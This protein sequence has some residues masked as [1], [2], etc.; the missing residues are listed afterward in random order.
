MISVFFRKSGLIVIIL[1]LLLISN[2]T[3]F[4]K[5]DQ[6]TP[7]RLLTDLICGSDEFSAKAAVELIEYP[8]TELQIWISEFKN[9]P[10]A[11]RTDD[12]VRGSHHINDSL[13]APFYTYV[14]DDYSRDNPTPLVIWLHGGVS[15]D[16]FVGEDAEDEWSK[17]PMVELAAKE[18]DMEIE[19]DGDGVNEKGFWNEKVIVSIDPKYFRPTEV[20]TLLGD[21]SKAKEKL[22]WEPKITLEEMVHEMMENDINIAKRDSLVK[23]HGF[24][25]PDFNE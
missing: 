21:P 10:K 7:N 12:L 24:K 15:R 3:S 17:H 14:P 25:A 11:K 22:G 4:S 6:D 16:E 23:K 18:L 2:S 9:F 19:W 5:A 13:D 1:A 20:E 8:T